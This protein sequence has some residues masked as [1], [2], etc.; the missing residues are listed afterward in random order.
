MCLHAE[1]LA[2]AKS[3]ASAK[4]DLK[5]VA[6]TGEAL[7]ASDQTGDHEASAFCGVLALSLSRRGHIRIR[8]LGDQAV[9]SGTVPRSCDLKTNGAGL[10]WNRADQGTLQYGRIGRIPGSTR[11]FF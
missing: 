5:L 11:V 9:F 8:R 2:K 6:R 10:G 3:K 1:R 4:G 7:E